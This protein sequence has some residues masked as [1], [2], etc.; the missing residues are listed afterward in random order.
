MKPNLISVILPNRNYAKYI[1]V[2]IQSV[3][4][5]SYLDWELIIIDDSSEDDSVERIQTYTAID[6]RILLIKN[7][8]NIGVAKSRNLG[9]S[10]SRGRFLAFLDSDD[11]W[12]PHRL[13]IQY[14]TMIRR[15]L[16]FT[17]TN[18]AK[19]RNE[20]EFEIIYSSKSKY[21]FKDLLGNPDFSIITIMLDKKQIKN[22]KFPKNLKK[23]EDYAF[24]LDI[25]KQGIVA[26][27][28]NIIGAFYRVGH[29]SLSFF[30][31][32]REVWE[33]L[34]YHLGKNIILRL[35]YF[36]LYLFNASRRR[37]NL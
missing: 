11:F 15:N 36:A 6:S 31:C 35:L 2:A 22:I 10:I 1:D 16:Q 25:L 18:Y 7:E 28:I 34:N 23:G 12:P 21:S 27:K 13:R 9:I 37:I 17:F 19:F 3:I 8:I 29:L 32:S 30:G 5:Q 24:H 33:I 20:N 4:A 14:E 26:N